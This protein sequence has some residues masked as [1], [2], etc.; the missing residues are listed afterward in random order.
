MAQC[1]GCVSDSKYAQVPGAARC[2]R[3]GLAVSVT[4]HA[5]DS[6][7][8]ESGDM[9]KRGATESSSFASVGMETPAYKEDEGSKRGLDTFQFLERIE[10]QAV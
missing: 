4:L 6:P 1:P 9:G 2:G 8:L 10:N 7:A 3:P 5:D